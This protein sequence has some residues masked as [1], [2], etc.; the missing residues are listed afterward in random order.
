MSTKITTIVSVERSKTFGQV[1]NGQTIRIL[2]AAWTVA[3]ND[4]LQ[5]VS[6]RTVYT[7]NIILP[8][9]YGTDDASLE[10]FKKDIQSLLDSDKV[11]VYGYEVS[12]KEASEGEHESVYNKQTGHEIM[13]FT[14]AWL[15]DDRNACVES[16]KRDLA[17][18]ITKETLRWEK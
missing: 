14:R 15:G 13:V 9:K 6:Q 10:A 3:S 1:V 12:V 4:L 2:K 11:Q 17:K 18:A 5:F 7:G 8:D 16:V